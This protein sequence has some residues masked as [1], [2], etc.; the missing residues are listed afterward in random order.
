MLEVDEFQASLG[1]YQDYMGWLNICH[2]INW[3]PFSSQQGITKFNMQQ[4]LHPKMQY[5]EDQVCM[6]SSLAY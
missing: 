6:V 5:M 1:F 3:N 4:W 2:K